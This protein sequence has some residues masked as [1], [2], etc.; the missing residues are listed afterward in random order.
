MAKGECTENE[1]N[2]EWMSVDSP[3]EAYGSSSAGGDEDGSPHVMSYVFDRANN[4]VTVIDEMCKEVAI[5]K[6]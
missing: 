5:L 2:F 4:N 1:M 3:C 6:E